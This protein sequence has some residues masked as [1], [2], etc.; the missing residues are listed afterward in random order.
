MESSTSPLSLKID[1]PPQTLREIAVDRLRKAILDGHFKSGD[2]LVERTLCDQMGV[3]RTVIRETLRY[4]EAE[5]LVEIQ[6]NRGPIVARLDPDQARQIYNIRRLLEADA[7]RDCAR[8][9]DAAVKLKLR[10]ALMQLEVAYAD[11]QPGVLTHA[12][13]EFYQAIFGAAGHD[14]AW[15]VVRRLNGRISRL[16]AMTLSTTDRHRSGFAHMTS[17]C[18][19]I[20]ENDAEAAAAAVSAHIDEA[21]AI[22]ERLLRA[23]SE[24]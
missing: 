21:S 19:A 15:E 2:R 22:A 12:T 3:S 24:Q 14:I 11:P 23:E 7:A 18:E 5:G 16:R 9:A 17:I 10:T 6:P 20:L 4:L 1:Q 13:T 8:R